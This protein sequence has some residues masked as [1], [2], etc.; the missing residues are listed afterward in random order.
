MDELQRTLNHAAV[1]VS[2]LL[3]DDERIHDLN[4]TFRG[5]DSPTNV[6]S[7]PVNGV[8]GIGQHE[9]VVPELIGDI[10]MSMET[11]MVEADAQGKS[12][13]DHMTHLWIHGLLHLFGYDHQTDHEA[14]E[15][16]NIYKSRI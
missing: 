5:K 13:E 1:S 16:E 15:M 3:C 14:V 12:F 9:G 8:I 4:R 11:L 2:V 6:L 10:V 7:F